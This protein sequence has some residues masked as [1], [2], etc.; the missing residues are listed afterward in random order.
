MKQ[1]AFEKKYERRWAAFEA[2]VDEGRGKKKSAAASA[3]PPAQA[4][5]GLYRQLCQHLALARDRVYSA[6]LTE[7]LN[8]L[9]LAGHQRLYGARG[10]DFSRFVDFIAGG[11]AREVRQESRVVWIGM[12]LLFIP[13]LGMIAWLQRS[14]EV[15]FY[16][17]S[18]DQLR[19]Y[20]AMYAPANKVLGQHRDAGSQFMMFGFYIWNNVKIDF[21]CF[22]GGIAFGLGSVFFLLFNGISIGNVAGHLTQLG[23]IQTFWGFVAGHSAFELVGAAISGAAGLKMGWALIAPGNHTR[24][25]AL[26]LAAKPAIRLL[27][28]AAIMTTAAAFIE[29]FWSSI[30]ATPFAL[31]VG[32]GIALWVFTACYFFFAGRGNVKV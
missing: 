9:V 3:I 5:P 31:K 11:F 24:L 25:E 4:L 14:P 13:L 1:E 27:Y 23:Y 22:A 7:R 28:G 26:K 29:A 20:E 2:W 30:S 21:Q 18:A 12:A 10:G 15:A 17:A 8:R 19:S 32:V 16:F 6:A